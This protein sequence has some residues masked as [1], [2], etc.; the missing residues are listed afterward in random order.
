MH[1]RA[2]HSRREFSYPPALA[3]ASSAWRSDPVMPMLRNSVA[4]SPAREVTCSRATWIVPSKTPKAHAR[5]R[6]HH[7][8]GPC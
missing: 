8:R 5:Q 2:E 7:S 4:T 6:V 1:R 3:M